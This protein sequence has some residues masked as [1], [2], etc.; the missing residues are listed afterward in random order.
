M[1]DWKI[2]FLGRW[3]IERLNDWKMEDE[4]WKTG[5]PD[6]WPRVRICS[7]YRI[8]VSHKSVDPGWIMGGL[9]FRSTAIRVFKCVRCFQQQVSHQ[10]FLRNGSNMKII[11]INDGELEEQWNNADLFKLCG[12]EILM[13]DCSPELWATMTDAC[14]DGEPEWR[15][16]FNCPWNMGEFIWQNC[17]NSQPQPSRS[18]G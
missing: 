7:H 1:K 5:R 11:S 15:N 13:D 6:R 17:T 9:R 12:D 14:V 16:V 10:F 4:R 18:N 2:E 3:K 8:S